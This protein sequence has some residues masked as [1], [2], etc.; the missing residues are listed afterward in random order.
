MR[1]Q[2]DVPHHFCEGVPFNLR[3]G[4]KDVLVGQQGVLAAASLLDRP[5]DNALSGFAYLA[6]RDVE[7]FYVHRAA[8]VGP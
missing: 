7:V 3:K 6:W 2:L 8:S 1:I 5:V 4:E